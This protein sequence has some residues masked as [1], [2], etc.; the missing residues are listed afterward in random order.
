MDSTSSL[1]FLALA[2]SAVL[3]LAACGASDYEGRNGVPTKG[4]KVTLQEYSDN[5]PFDV[6][7]GTLECAGAGVAVFHHGGDSYAL[8]DS[9]LE[10]GYT[11]VEEVRKGG[12]KLEMK[13]YDL[14]KQSGAM[15]PNMT[16]YE[17]FVDSFGTTAVFYKE[18]PQLVDQLRGDLGA[19]TELA[20]TLC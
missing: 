12:G 15:S 14:A 2:A 13:H 17:I 3:F 10:N 8:N 18:F 6:K 4:L 20:L 7:G 9:A 11:L 5:W 1:I 19:M 16:S